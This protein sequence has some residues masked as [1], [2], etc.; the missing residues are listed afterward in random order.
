MAVDAQ[1]IESPMLLLASEIV[2]A[3]E[4]VDDLDEMLSTA[5]KRKEELEQKL[6]DLM[7]NDEVEKFVY[8]GKTF[9]PSVKLWASL[10]AETKE[11]AVEWLK[12]SEFSDIVKEQVNSQSLSALVKEL[13]DNGDLPEAFEQ[14]LNMTDKITLNIR[15]GRG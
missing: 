11:Q 3:R 1:K 13:R 2:K 5:K 4:I 14:Y 8:A 6:L 12:D 15:K 10:K 7:M 9:Y